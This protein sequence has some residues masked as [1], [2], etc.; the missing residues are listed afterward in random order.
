MVV[1]R[2]L[3]ARSIEEVISQSSRIEKSIKQ[4]I[5]QRD[6][7]EDEKG[8]WKAKSQESRIKVKDGARSK[9]FQHRNQ[10]EGATHPLSSEQASARR[11]LG[12]PTDRKASHVAK[13]D[14][15]VVEMLCMTDDVYR[16]RGQ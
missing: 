2:W 4:R 3:M 10:E 6:E 15:I 16:G 1:G 12:L 13:R 11:E 5:R 8:K 7:A 9:R 14:V